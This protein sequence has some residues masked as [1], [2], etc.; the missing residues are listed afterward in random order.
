[1]ETIEN[2][3]STVS[4]VSQSKDWFDGKAVDELMRVSQLPGMRRAVGFPDMHS[5]M[6]TPNG[7]AFLSEGVFYPHLI[8]NDIGCGYHLAQTDIR[9]RKQKLDRWTKR[10]ADLDQPWNGDVQTWLTQRGLASTEFDASMGTIGGGNHFAELQEVHRVESKAA[11]A[12]AGLDSDKLFVLVHSGSRGLGQRILRSHVDAHR[13]DGLRVGTK[14]AE[15]YESQHDH[16]VCWARANRGLIA[17]RFASQINARLTPVLDLPHNCMQFV[18]EEG[19]QYWLHRKGATATGRGLAVIPGSRGAFTYLVWPL[20]NSVEHLW[21]IAHGAGRKWDRGSTE[22]R[23]RDYYRKQS[24][25]QTELGGR[26]ICEDKSLLYQEAPLAYKN[27]EKVIEQLVA[28]GLIEVV[29]TLRPLIT[30]KKRSKQ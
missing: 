30:Y 8:G 13:A 23:M 12:K 14:D 27:I 28:D 22:A 5:G 24:L 26:V 25:V 15:A 3:K 29:A 2:N 19:R 21:S 11:F 4:F 10:L 7:A 6:D 20:K 16:A 18:I 17:E 9:K 1:M